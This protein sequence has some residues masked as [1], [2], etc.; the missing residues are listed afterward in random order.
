MSNAGTPDRSPRGKPAGGAR[1]SALYGFHAVGVRLRIA[2]DTVAEVHVDPQRRDARMRQF[3]E[4][5][6]AAGA[7]IVRAARLA[8]QRAKVLMRM[9]GTERHPLVPVTT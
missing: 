3:V 1:L 8:V 7:A 2:P 6:R 5:A 4:R 9:V